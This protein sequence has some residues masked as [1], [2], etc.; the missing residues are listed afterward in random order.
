MY[1]LDP[2]DSRCVSEWVAHIIVGTSLLMGIWLCTIMVKPK[3]SQDLPEK[4]LSSAPELAIF[5]SLHHLSARDLTVM[6]CVC[7]TVD[8][9]AGER[10]IWKVLWRRRYGDILESVPESLRDIDADHAESSPMLVLLSCLE[11]LQMPP[12]WWIKEQQIS[13]FDHASSLQ[14]QFGARKQWKLCYFVF[15]MHW[16]KWVVAEHIRE[17]NCWLVIHGAIFNMT[18][19]DYHP[20]GK[21]PFMRFAGFDATEAFE[22]MGHSWFGKRAGF[23]DELLVDWLRIPEEG[24][25]L[26]P[27]W[28]LRQDAMPS[29]K[30]ALYDIFLLNANRQLSYHDFW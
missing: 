17:D 7:P 9:V 1:L 8:E 6:S 21:K 18:H 19:F 30:K 15:G 27:A 2:L 23:G 24:S 4:R 3:R 5:L 26:R 16:Q 25:I 29:W 28:L 12:R 14:E 11:N 20:G 22:A 13:Y 10:K